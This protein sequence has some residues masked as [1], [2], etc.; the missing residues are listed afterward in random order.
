V[1]VQA[2]GLNNSITIPVQLQIDLANPART[3]I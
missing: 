1:T 2:S 3:L